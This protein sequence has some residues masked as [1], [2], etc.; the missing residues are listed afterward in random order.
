MKYHQY[1]T[2]SSVSDS[3]NR[4]SAMAAPYKVS[5]VS[6]SPIRVSAMTAPMRSRTSSAS[7]PQIVELPAHGTPDFVH[8]VHAEP[9]AAPLVSL[10]HSPDNLP[11]SRSS[12][13]FAATCVPPAPR[14]H[15]DAFFGRPAAPVTPRTPID[16]PA[17][18]LLAARHSVPSLLEVQGRPYDVGPDARL[19]AV[20]AVLTRGDQ[21]QILNEGASRC[22]TL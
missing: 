7:R 19:E 14:S 8:R 12:T 21:G 11:R 20:L 16:C 13:N 22:G 9:H 4:V 2:V 18:G 15:F 3:P 6:N 1:L 10:T 5:S 17:V